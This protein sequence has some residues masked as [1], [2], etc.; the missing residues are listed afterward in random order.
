M[1]PR[2]ARLVDAAADAIL[3]VN[4]QT[5]IVYAN[6]AASALLGY[7]RLEFIGSTLRDITPLE[8]RADL[9]ARWRTF[10]VDG[11]MLG[12]R[13]LRHKA[14]TT[15]AI[16]C[17]GVAHLFYRLH[18]LQFHRAP[19]AAPESMLQPS[20]ELLS[21]IV[22]H[23]PLML[24]L[25]DGDGR[26]FWIN[27]EWERVFGW[28]LE[29]ARQTDVLAASCPDLAYR[30]EVREFLRASPHWRDFRLVRKDGATIDTAW[31]VVHLTDG[32][33]MCIGKDISARKR[34]EE[35]FR[36]TQEQLRR[37]A[38]RVA[39]AIERERTDVSRELHD[40]L[41]QL[42]T[43]LKMELA[44]ADREACQ[45]SPSRRL[46][47]K[48]AIANASVDVLI[49]EVRRISAGLRPIALDRLGLVD[50]IEWQAQD[51][52]RRTGIRCRFERN[53]DTIEIDTETGAQVVRILQEALTNA[54]RHSRASRV[55]IIATAR[56]DAFSLAIRDNGRGISDEALADP[57]ALG[58]LGM[59]ERALLAGGHLT[60]GRHSRRGTL[61]SVSIPTKRPAVSIP[62][63]R[64]RIA[65][66]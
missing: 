19:E 5:D 38:G 16:E 43:A 33:I 7:T 27:K 11:R 22:D 45:S 49:Q 18:A 62:V 58:L 47:D 42:L 65:S 15:A 29:E 36:T 26:V 50:A 17:H 66:A 2:A 14:G 34:R 59:H 12:F 13:A 3:I 39:H 8:H 25:I 48:L 23:V 10:L 52:E 63:R 4:N 46:S 28:S 21:K 61:V 55:M 44:D 6:P 40:Q 60:I 1:P 56:R 54:V 35:E 24:S 31:A 37:L 20:E 57:D 9:A 41:G 64:P 53:A 51:F 32:R 30:E